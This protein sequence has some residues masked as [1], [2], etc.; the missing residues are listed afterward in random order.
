MIEELVL[1]VAI[2]ALLAVHD[3]RVMWFRVKLDWGNR[4]RGLDP[5]N[6][7]TSLRHTTDETCQ[8]HTRRQMWYVIVGLS[9]LLVV[10]ILWSSPPKSTQEQGKKKQFSGDPGDYK[11]GL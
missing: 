5:S 11:L 7:V 9:A 8:P 2:L 1:V 10:L 4:H 6:P 3:L